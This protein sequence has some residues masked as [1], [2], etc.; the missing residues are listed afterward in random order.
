MPSGRIARAGP[1]ETRVEHHGRVEAV[2]RIDHADHGKRMSLLA[3]GRHVERRDE[4]RITAGIIDRQRV[5]VNLQRYR[6]A[7]GIAAGLI[8]VGVIGEEILAVGDVA[9]DRARLV[10][11]VIEQAA[12]ARP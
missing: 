6:N 2:E 9:D 3:A 1:D 11:G 10:L 4:L 5:A 7:Y 12:R 8:L